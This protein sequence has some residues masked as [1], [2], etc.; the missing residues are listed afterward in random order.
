MTRLA[1]RRGLLPGEVFL[2]NY[3]KTM[4]SKTKA[5]GLRGGDFIQ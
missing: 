1:A 5:G 2:A 3:R 4:F